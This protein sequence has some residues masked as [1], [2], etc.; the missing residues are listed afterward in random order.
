LKIAWSLPIFG[1]FASASV[2][3]EIDIFQC[4]KQNIQQTVCKKVDYIPL[5]ICFC[6]IETEVLLTVGLSDGSIKL[7]N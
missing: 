6:P 3:R 5:A 4:A 1:L 7:M 2:S